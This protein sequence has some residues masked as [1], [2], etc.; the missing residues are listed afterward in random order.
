MSTPEEPEVDER[1]WLERLG[2]V[3]PPRR[4]W[5]PLGLTLAAGLV[6]A[7]VGGARLGAPGVV[8][9]AAAALVVVAFFVSSPLPLT[10]T[11]ALGAERGAG[12]VLLLTN[13]GLRVL[14]ALAL[15]ALLV[16]AGWADRSAVGLSVVVCAVVRV[17]AQ[18]LLTRPDPA[19]RRGGRGPG[20]T[21]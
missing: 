17:N 3:P 14:L 1:P 21:G 9:G 11:E 13:Y 6:C 20:R 4:P 2:E 7:G 15:P 8:S 5:L 12:L 19:R 10:I 16:T 18:A